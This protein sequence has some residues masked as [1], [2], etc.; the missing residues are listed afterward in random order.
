MDF[1]TFEKDYRIAV[2]RDKSV[3]GPAY[4]PS[5][6]VGRGDEERL[7]GK[8]LFLGVKEDFLP[9]MIRV[10]GL[11]ESGKTVVVKHVLEDFSEYKGDVVRYFFVNLKNCRTVLSAG[12]AILSVV[13]GKKVPIN[14]GLDRVFEELWEAVKEFKKRGT[15]FF[16]FVLDEAD[17]IFCDKH[18]DASDFFYRFIRSSSTVP[19]L[20]DVKI[21]VLTITNDLNVLEDNLEARVKSNMGSE[22]IF[23]SGYSKE[24]LEAILRERIDY[25]FVPERV[26]EGVIS[27]CA[28]LAAQMGGDARKAIELLRIGGEKV[29]VTDGKVTKAVIK[30]SVKEAEDTALKERLRLLTSEAKTALYFLANCVI[31]KKLPWISMSDFYDFYSGLNF[32]SGFRKV[33]RR[34][35]LQI[36]DDLQNLGFLVTCNVS[37]GRGGYM[38]E[39]SF[40]GDPNK[41]MG[42]VSF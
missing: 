3:L 22:S 26:E 7:L 15:L 31:Y 2:F 14:L 9:P 16:V 18:F 21:C 30:E 42:S 8:I 11:P 27:Y 32:G 38:K 34:R 25:A 37:K 41:I 1:R 17:S 10:F 36:I 35:L 28:E 29:Q 5:K 19:G 39:I 33:G 12:N 6:L 24:D 23:F 13:C 20:E 4:V 40:V